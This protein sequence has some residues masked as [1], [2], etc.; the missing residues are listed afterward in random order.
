MVQCRVGRGLEPAEFRQVFQARSLQREDHLGQIQ[1]LDLRHLPAGRSFCSSLDHRPEA[2]T[3]GRASGASRT[4]IG[5]GLADALDKKRIDPAIRIV[6]GNT[7]KAAIDDETDAVDGDRGFR[8]IRGD[9]D[10]R[11]LI[12][13][14][15][16][17]LILR[18]QLTVQRKNEISPAIPSVAATRRSCG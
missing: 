5:A 7:R 13:G 8:D 10:L 16:G 15:G 1:P 17:V 12:A 9:D 4:L 3:R 2:L 11:L 6:P 18:R 14:N